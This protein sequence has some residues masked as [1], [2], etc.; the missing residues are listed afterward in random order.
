MGDRYHTFVYPSVVF[1]DNSQHRALM[2]EASELFVKFQ[3]NINHCCE[4]IQ[5]YLDSDAGYSLKE[6][7]IYRTQG[8]IDLNHDHSG[9]IA[10]LYE[11]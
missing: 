2:R 1:F 7:I 10:A 6:E 4:W 9:E 8:N 11:S 3:D 5:L